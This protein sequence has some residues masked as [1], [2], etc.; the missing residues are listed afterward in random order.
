METFSA[1]LTTYE[2]NQPVTGWFPSG[3]RRP[4]MRNF[5]V[6]FNL[7]LNKREA[8]STLHN[9]LVPVMESVIFIFV[10]ILF[11]NPHDRI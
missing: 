9:G 5:D 10:I 1:L 7:S 8:K 6:F 11:I 3:Q 4:V 2:E